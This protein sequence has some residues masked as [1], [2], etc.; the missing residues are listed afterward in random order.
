M[1]KLKSIC[2]VFIICSLFSCN[3]NNDQKEEA[4]NETVTD[5]LSSA[6]SSS[7]SMQTITNRS[8]I[9][10]VDEESP[11]VDKLRKPE[12]ANLDTFSSTHLIGLI[13][14]SFPDIHIDLVKI[15]H[16]TMYI[17]IPDSKRLTQEIGDTGA[18]NYMAS[19]T[20]T[21]TELKNIKFINFMFTSGDHA[22]PGVYSRKDFGRLR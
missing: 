2:I 4:R 1:K 7:D 21:L 15:S 13:N 19:T 14:K 5:T 3:S 17:K 11:G 10:S 12:T 9:W 22:E 8:L 6:V 20:Y 18:E 16:D